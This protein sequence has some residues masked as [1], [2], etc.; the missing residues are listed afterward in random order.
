MK[1][2][3]IPALLLLAAFPLCGCAQ[4]EE[5]ENPHRLKTQTVERYQDGG[6]QLIRTEYTYDENNR[7]M[8]FHTSFC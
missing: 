4:A 8:E 5:S 2:R 7:V 3:S 1:Y 6:V